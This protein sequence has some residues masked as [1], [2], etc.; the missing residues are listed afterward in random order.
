[1]EQSPDM[2]LVSEALPLPESEEAEL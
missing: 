2:E 1:M